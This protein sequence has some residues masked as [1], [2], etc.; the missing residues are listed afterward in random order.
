MHR[1]PENHRCRRA[2]RQGPI[3]MIS[4]ISV[5]SVSTLAQAYSV[6]AA[7]P[8]GLRVLAGGTDLMVQINAR[9]DLDN[10]GHVLDIW[11]LHPLRGIELRGDRLSIGALKI[12]R[13]SC[14]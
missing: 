3:E 12:G 14:R 5:T 13:A 9:V 1:L 2:G 11:G 10:L 6:L 7:K 8:P 4:R